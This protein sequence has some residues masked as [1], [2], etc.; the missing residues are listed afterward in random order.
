MENSKKIT[1][2]FKGQKKKDVIG[3]GA[4]TKGNVILNYC[5]INNN[6]IS[7]ICDANPLKRVSLL[8]EVILK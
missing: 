5:N 2:F 8:L 3:Y 4:S 7:F 1:T 6:D